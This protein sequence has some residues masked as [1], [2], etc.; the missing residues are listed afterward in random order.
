M[1]I[2]ELINGAPPKELGDHVCAAILSALT[3]FYK[4]GVSLHR[5]IYSS[6][7]KKTHKLPC[8]VACIGNLTLGGSGKTPVVIMAARLLSEAGKKVVILSRGYKRL[9]K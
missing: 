5:K 3:P 7:I 4:I 8:R 9:S 1:G 6:G 2:T